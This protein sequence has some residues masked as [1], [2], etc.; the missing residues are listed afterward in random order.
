M[1]TLLLLATGEAQAAG[2]GST[3]PQVIAS[4]VAAVVTTMSGG[5]GLWYLRRNRQA[6]DDRGEQSARAKA[7][8]ARDN[9][10]QA[11]REIV[12]GYREQLAEVKAD[13]AGTAA[14]VA[15]IR[16]DLR[17]IDRD[18][19]TLRSELQQ[20]IRDER[21]GAQG[22]AMVTAA[23]ALNERLSIVLRDIERRGGDHAR[24]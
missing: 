22:A 8:I 18:L 13:A 9:A 20:A 16:D 2:H 17:R 14:A 6:G 7:A 4:I 3:D 5:G 15:N 24:R 19:G 10:D 23:N 1:L 21:A 12:T 11:L